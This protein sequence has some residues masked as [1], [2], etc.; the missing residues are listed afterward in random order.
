MIAMQANNLQGAFVKLVA[1]D[2]QVKAF[3]SKYQELLR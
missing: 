1:K 3:I 2:S